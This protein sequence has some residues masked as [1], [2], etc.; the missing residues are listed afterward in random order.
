M[1]LVALQVVQLLTVAGGFIALQ[2]CS[3]VLGE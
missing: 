1:I 2:E 3:R